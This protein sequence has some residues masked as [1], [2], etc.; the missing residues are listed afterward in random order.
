VFPEGA[1]SD[2]PPKVR[3]EIERLVNDRDRAAEVKLALSLGTE[4]SEDDDHLA[5][6][7]FLAWA[8]HLAPRSPVVRETYAIAL[9]R[10]G[11]FKAAL[12]E[13]QAYRRISGSDDQNHL[14]ADCIR[15]E[16]RE[17]DR[18]IEIGMLLVDAED[19]DIERRVEA[20]IVV[21]AVQLDLGRPQRAG[22]VLARF[23]TP[24]VS[25]DVPAESRV[26]LLWMVADA[27]EAEGADAR[28][29]EALE[30]LLSID[31][32]Y[33][34]ADERVSRLRGRAGR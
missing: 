30:R 2:L 4:A 21:A 6:R 13:L 28:A 14:L 27:A 33:P 25:K 32:E 31:P 19:Q 18:A 3:K 26:R 15:A 24:P 12:S 17:P 23:L 29:L 34:D 10:S 11:D 20:A 16:G 5:A 9:Y 22:A 8:K 1:E 7:R